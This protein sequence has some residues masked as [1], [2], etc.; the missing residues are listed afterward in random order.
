MLKEA[1]LG[2]RDSIAAGSHDDTF[3]S[4]LSRL[5]PPARF[6]ALTVRIIPSSIVLPPT[7][8]FMPP[9][10]PTPLPTWGFQFGGTLKMASS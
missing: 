10:T 4:T 6:L 2:V 1:F 9:P 5:G 7:S 8:L 3:E